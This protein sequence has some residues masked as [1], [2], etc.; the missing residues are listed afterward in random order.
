[1][2]LLNDQEKVTLFIARNFKDIL[3]DQAVAQLLYAESVKD[4][5]HSLGRSHRFCES[6]NS[7]SENCSSE[8]T[9]K[10]ADGY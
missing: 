6:F 1:M 4:L 2:K 9:S 7:S 8:I 5:I 3:D 10:Y